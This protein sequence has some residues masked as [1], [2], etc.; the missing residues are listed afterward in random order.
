M[1]VRGKTTDNHKDFLAQRGEALAESKAKA[2]E[3]IDAFEG[4]FVLIGLN[5]NKK[6][7]VTGA[8]KMAA[9]IGEPSD[10][11]AIGDE[12]H[13][14]SHAII[15]DVLADLPESNKLSVLLGMMISRLKKDK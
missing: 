13:T 7:K 8:S 3:M 10:V 15:E 4:T 12:L 6:L 5:Y 9:L 2:H 1:A 14:A 11:I